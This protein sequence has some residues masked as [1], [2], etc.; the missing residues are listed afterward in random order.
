MKIIILEIPQLCLRIS[1]N[2]ARKLGNYA[3]QDVLIVGYTCIPEFFSSE[4]AS[5][6]HSSQ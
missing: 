2:R 3:C 5:M 4:I 1:F 6:I